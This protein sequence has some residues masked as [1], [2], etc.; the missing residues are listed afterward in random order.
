PVL[1]KIASDD[2]KKEVK[3]AIVTHSTLEV[4]PELLRADR[5]L[6]ELLAKQLTEQCKDNGEKVSI[7]PTRKIEEYKN[8]H[9]GWKDDDLDEIGKHFNADY[10][11]FLEINELDLTMH[12]SF[13]GL[14]RGRARIQV[15]LIDVHNPEEELSESF[16][17]TYPTESK[18]G[19]M[20]ND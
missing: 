5:Q 13:G 11:I 7:V 8:Q 1:K 17:C 2:K 14:L 12:G 20:D 3:A 15:S 4:R 9:P 19:V 6:S 18:G 10:V 16:E